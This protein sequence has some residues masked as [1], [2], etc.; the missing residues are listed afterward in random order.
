MTGKVSSQ[1]WVGV[2]EG[3]M[4]AALWVQRSGTR[5]LPVDMEVADTPHVVLC[6]IALTRAPVD[7]APKACLRLQAGSKPII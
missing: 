2:Y 1:E 6:G 3:K 7:T 5:V 4:L